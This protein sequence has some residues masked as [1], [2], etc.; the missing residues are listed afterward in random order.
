ML[1]RRRKTWDTR[2]QRHSSLDGNGR[3]MNWMPY[4]NEDFEDWSRGRTKWLSGWVGRT[5]KK[6]WAP[7]NSWKENSGHHLSNHYFLCALG[8]KYQGMSFSN[9]GNWFLG[10]DVL[11][12]YCSN[13]RSEKASTDTKGTLS[14]TD[15]VVGSKKTVTTTQDS[16]LLQTWVKSL[17]GP[18]SFS[19]KWEEYCS[20]HRGVVRIKS[21]MSRK[22]LWG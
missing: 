13:R 7:R 6:R 10:S 22:A 8:Q 2:S 21:L 5:I 12:R 1:T 18:N 15:H 11:K 9:R 14:W 3:R 16:I 17:L 4:M 20:P 19:V